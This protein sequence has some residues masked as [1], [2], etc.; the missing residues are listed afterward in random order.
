MGGR[1]SKQS[2]TKNP[3]AGRSTGQEKQYS[4]RQKRRNTMEEGQILV[5]ESQ[6]LPAPYGNV[7]N[8][9]FYDGIPQYRRS[10][11]SLKSRSLRVSEVSSLLGRAGSVGLGRAVEVLDTLGSSM[12]NL[13]SSRGFVSGAST[14]NNELSILAFEVANTI[15]KGSNLMHSLSKRSIRKLKD[16]VLPAESVQQLISTDEDKLLKIVAADKREE[17]KVFLEEVVRFGNRCKDPQWHNLDRFFEK[18]S[19]DRNPQKHS[20]EVAESVMQQLMTSV[21]LTAELYQEQHGL[22]RF[23]Q[24]FLLRRLEEFKNN[25]SQKGDRDHNLIIMAA[26][27][28]SQKKLVKSLKKK[29]LWSRRMEDV[30]GQLVDI[31]LFLN[32]EIN[33]TL[34]NPAVVEGR[35]PENGSHSSQQ[36]LG[37]AGLALHYANIILQIDSIVARSSSVSPKARDTLYQSLP[38]NV[39]A[40][41]RSKMQSFKIEKELTVTEI[42]DEME[43]TLSWLVPTATNTAKDH[44]GFGWV[45]EWANTGSEQNRRTAAA[46]ID[47]MKI[48]TL[49][50]A[51]RQKTETY[52]LDLLLWLN[53]LVSRS[54]SRPKAIGIA[55]ITPLKESEE[56]P[57]DMKNDSVSSPSLCKDDQELILDKTDTRLGDDTPLDVIDRVEIE[58]S[59]ADVDYGGSWS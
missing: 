47:V 57:I 48:E 39:K 3:Y 24:D 43:K 29:S 20:R 17:L 34:G 14:Q 7:S 37:D 49:Q 9:E 19:S 10:S 56:Q 22:E 38:P 1:S 59:L 51:D 27:L 30:M 15:V 21:Q 58:L 52:I 42:K 5:K 11:L 23:E 54:K 55:K 31:V 2:S 12:T 41:L 13:N 45:G 6:K 32:Q 4:Q 36:T 44:H 8:D 40:S 25:A 50:H 18:R 53:Y 35:R 28:K 46:P 33:N 16:V 26:E